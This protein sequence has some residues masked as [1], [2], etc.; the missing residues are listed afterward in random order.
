MVRALDVTV[1]RTVIQ[2]LR[3]FFCVEFRER[4]TEVV[5]GY[6]TFIVLLLMHSTCL[7][8]VYIGYAH[9]CRGKGYN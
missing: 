5:D 1:N 8:K 3:R 7:G 6:H 4:N 2:H 9:T